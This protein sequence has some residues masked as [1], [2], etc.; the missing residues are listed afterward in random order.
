MQKTAVNCYPV[1]SHN[2]NPEAH[3]RVN[4]GISLYTV[5]S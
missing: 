2:K 4:F 3:Y 5:H 1:N